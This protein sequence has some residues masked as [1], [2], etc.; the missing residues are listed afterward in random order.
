MYDLTHRP[1]SARAAGDRRPTAGRSR[2]LVHW[3]AAAAIGAVL[4]GVPVAPAG[5]Q[6]D[7][8]SE[9]DRT[10]G[11]RTMVTG[12]AYASGKLD[13]NR[14]S[15][16][17]I[18]TLPIPLDV[19]H[20]IWEYRTYVSYFGDIYDLMEIQGFTPEM[21]ARL[22]PLV[23]TLP[24][25]RDDE[26]LERLS[27]SYRQVR[28]YLG[29]EGASEGLV[30]EYLDQL[31]DPANINELDLFDLMSYQNVSPVDA[32]A[33]LKARERLGGF[34]SDRQLRG[35]EGLR[36]WAFRNLRDF[37]VYGDAAQAESSGGRLRGD[38]QIRF[39]ESPY[40]SDDDE[41]ADAALGA[42]PGG[43]YLVS[44]VELPRPALTQKLRFALDD[45]AKAGVLTSRYYGEQDWNETSKAFVSIQ[46]QHA[47][48]FHLKNLVVG[49][50]RA[51][52]GL[53]LVMDNTDFF[54]YRKTGYDFNKRPI[55]VGG[56]LSRTREYGLRGA[57]LESRYGPVYGTFF[58][59]SLRK[60]AVLNPDDGT[61]NR[62][63]FLLP[64]V[65]QEVIDGRE[66]GTGLVDPTLLRRDALQ[67]DLVGGNVRLMLGTGTYLGVTGYE[68][69]YNRGF[70]ADVAT[71]VADTTLLEARDSE[72][73]QGYTS[74]FTEGDEVTTHRFRRVLG[75]EA[76]T[77]ISNVALQAEYAFL[78]DPRNSLFDGDNPDALVVNAYTQFDDLH[79]LAIYRDYDLGFDNP[80]NRAFANDNRYEQ[81][82]LDAPY[83]LNDPLF[84]FLE[85]NN[86]QPKPE[87]GLFFD[88]RYRVS[89]TLTL[90]GFQFDQWE[91][92][93]DGADLTRYTVKAEYQPI[94]ALRFR[95]RHRYSSRTEQLP[96]D[97]RTFR[98]WETRWQLVALLSNFNRL[99]FTYMTS[100]VQ[101]PARQRLSGLPYPSPFDPAVGTAAD[102]SKVLE[103]RYEHNLTPWITLSAASTMYDGFF[104]NFE[105]NE[106]VL[107]DGVGYR[108]WF[109]FESRVSERLLL[110][111][112]VTRD[113]NLPRTYVD[114][115]SFGEELRPTPDADY[116]P[117]DVLRLAET[118]LRMAFTER[119][120]RFAS[121]SAKAMASSRTVPSSQ[122]RS[123]SPMV[124]ASSA[125][126][127][128]PSSIISRAFERP[129]R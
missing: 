32:V 100:N 117:R 24:P 109:K 62:M 58:V 74:V 14:A 115:R 92:K 71:L 44:D 3:L 35:S 87:K 129:T 113:H 119:G 57:A 21:L 4:G 99:Q 25:E 76:Q 125:S 38:Y 79:L 47:G 36:Y 42:N 66:P 83:R 107:L 123:T 126:T 15:A 110:Q 19:A 16:E 73:W 122:R 127:W 89:R 84:T 69:T 56:D 41:L 27:A 98:N 72:I 75:A 31:R 77:V 40:F 102:P 29:Q 60:D 81:T 30:D 94:F 88:A 39:S 68:A 116:A 12:G 22:K 54:L 37:V 11:E 34:E 105:G 85:L 48:Q 33:I 93:A 45:D 96:G 8:Q 80:Y 101:F 46:D 55:G 103:V 9:S 95:A 53:G 50:F 28:R 52:F 128:R 10:T 61:V 59:S 64:R 121:C 18:A 111:L 23:A 6:D 2:R 49:D 5:A 82:L 97:V 120:G 67:E 86:P 114:I 118:I 63:I 90:T 78:Q 1:G 70:R 65:E 17:Q 51:A 43:R 112:K 20:R 108:N 106:F 7:P 104:W 26:A 13:L 91:R 124:R